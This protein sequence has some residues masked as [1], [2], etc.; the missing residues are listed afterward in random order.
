MRGRPNGI[1]DRIV[2]VTLSAGSPAPNVRR[3]MQGVGDAERERDPILITS[4]QA[5]RACESENGDYPGEREDRESSVDP[6]PG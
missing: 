1:I 4:P 6:S 3:H 2:A 5:A